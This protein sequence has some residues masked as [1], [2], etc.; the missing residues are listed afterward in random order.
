MAMVDV[1][2]GLALLQLFGFGVLVGRARGRY[3]VSAPAVTGHEVFERYYRVQMN[4]IELLVLFVPASYIAARYVA[5]VWVAGLG[6]VYLVGRLIY[7][8]AYIS[9]P[10]SRGLGFGL[11]VLPTLALVVISLVGAGLSLARG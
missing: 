11:S 6:A 2:V 5:P 10:K 1:V 9:D 8:R 4:T 3:G 7:L